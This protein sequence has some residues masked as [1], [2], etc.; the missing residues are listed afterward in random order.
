[1]QPMRP[2]SP[3]RK[4][5]RLP[6]TPKPQRRALL[7]IV[8]ASND[9]SFD[10]VAMVLGMVDVLLGATLLAAIKQPWDD[11]SESIAKVAQTDLASPTAGRRFF[12]AF[13]SGSWPEVESWTRD[14]L[15]LGVLAG[16][17]TWIR[18]AIRQRDVETHQ[19]ISAS[20]RVEKLEKHSPVVIEIATILG[21]VGVVTFGIIAACQR[22]MN[23]ARNGELKHKLESI[24][25]ADRQ[26]ALKQQRIRTEV[27]SDL[28]DSYKALGIGRPVPAEALAEVAKIAHVPIVEA[29]ES[30]LIKEMNFNAD[31][32]LGGA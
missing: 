22:V 1:M 23:G 2:P 28:R 29:K 27:L 11:L 21:G 9:H 6:P 14:P 25:L 24:A 20:V 26:E 12:P 32:K 16:M 15:D 17:S 7:T 18:A 30:S 31:V 5:S 3:P 10:D 19:Q 8:M 13:A 4:G